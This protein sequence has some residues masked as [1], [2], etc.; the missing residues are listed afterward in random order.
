MKLLYSLGVTIVMTFFTSTSFA[1]LIAGDIAFIGYNT[2]GTDNFAFITLADIP[3]GEVIY[4]TEEGWD[5]SLNNWA[6]TTEGHVTY[7]APAGGLTCGT[8]IHINETTPDVFTVTGGGTAT[9]SSGASWSLSAGDQVLAYQAATPEP[10]TVPTFISGVHGDDG[11]GAPLSLD[12]TTGWNNNAVS[13]LGTARSNLPPGLTNGTNCISLFPAIGT[14]LDNAKYNGTLTGTSAALRAAINDRTN[15]IAD[16]TTPYGLDPG[17]FPAPS[18]TCAPPCTDPT[19]PTLTSTPATV[20]SGGTATLNITGTL[21][22][23][24][25]WQVYTGSCG[26]TNIGSTTTGTFAIPGPITVPTTYFVRGEGGCVTPGTCGT[27]TITPQALDDASF[28]Y[29]AASYCVSDAD[30]TPTITGLPG[31]TFSSTAGLSINA[32]T[33]QIDVSASTP[34]TYT[35]TYTTS[36]TCPNSSNV[37]VTIN[38][39]DDPSFSYSASSYCVSDADPTPTITGLAGGIFSST[40]GLSINA[41]TGTID[42]SAST[43]NTYTITYT[44]SGPCPNSSGVLVTISALDD[45]S[46]SYSASSFCPTGPDP[47]PTITGL[48]GGMFSSTAGLSINAGTG[49]I[50]VSASTPNTYTVTYTTAGPCPNSSNVSVTVG[51]VI[52]PVITCPGDQTQAVDAACQFILADYT[53]LATA[54]D[55]CTASPT[56]TQIPAPGTPVTG[57]VTVQLTANDGNGNTANCNFNVIGLDAVAP[58]IACPGDQ[59]GTVN[60]TCQFIL[61]D[62]T[63]LATVND[64]C[65]GTSVTQSPAPG[66]AVG[67][68]VTVITLTATDVSA[69]SA[70]CTFNVTVSDA[71][72]PTITCP[73][74]QTASLDA[75]CQFTLPDYTSLAT[76]TDNCTASPTVTQSPAAGTTVTGNTT[77]TLTATDGSGN[78]SSC[79]FD[80]IV[81]DA[82]APTAV[83]QNIT[84]FL[85][86]AGNATI[87]AADID[88][89]STDNCGPVTLSASTTSFTCA[90]I[91]LNNVT[92]TATDAALNTANCVAVVTVADTTAPVASCPGNQTETA[93]PTCDFTLPD[94]TGL[95]TASDNCG[96]TTVTQSPVAGTVI[97][98]NTTIT[99]TTTD[100]SG[101]STT[102]TFDVILTG[103]ST[104]NAVCQDVTVYLDA[105]GNAS[106]VP[107]DIDGGSTVGCGGT[108]NLAASQTSFTCADIPVGATPTADMVI[109]G[110]YDG[111]LTGG[112]PKGIELYVINDIADLSQ[113]GVGSANNGGGTDGEEFT[114]PAVSATAGQFIYIASEAPEFTNWFGFA[115]DYTDFSMAINGDDAVE[116][117]YQGAVIDVFGDINT[118]GT[119]QPWEYLDGWA[120]RMNDTGN[121][122]SAWTPSNWMYSGINVLDGETANAT[123]ASPVPVGTFT[124]NVATPTSVTLTVTDGQGG[125]ATCTANV[126]VLDTVSPVA[127]CQDATVYLDATGNATITAADVTNSGFQSYSVDQTGTF[128]PLSSPISGTTVSLGDDAVSPALP[129]GFNFDFYGNSYTDFYISSNGFMTFSSGTG[130]GCCSGQFLPNT[131]N[132][133][134][135]I[136]FAWEDLDPGNGG[137]P[138]INLVQYTT[139]GTAPNRVLVMEFYNV[140]HFPSGNNVTTQV[141]LY[142]TT[143]M[144]EIHTTNMPSDGGSHTMGLEN[145]DGTMATLVP[146]RNSQNWSATNDYVAFI[147]VFG[148]NT[149]NCGV[150]SE[151]IDISSFTCADLGAT[152]PVTM[153]VTDNSGNT[154]TCTSQVTVLDTIAPTFTCPADIVQDQDAGVCSASVTVPNIVT[155]D[156]CGGEIITW[157]ITTPIST[158]SNIGQIGLQGIPVGLTTVDVTVTDPSGNASNCSFTITVNDTVAPTQPVLADSIAECS[159]TLTAPTTTDNCN[160]TITG[161][162]TDPTTIST[163]GTTVVTWTFDDGS[164][165]ITTATQNVIIN[166]AIAPTASDLDTVFAECI[167]DVA[168]DI[169]LVDDEADNCTAAPVVAYVGDV[170]SNGTGCNDTITRTYSVTDDA[171]NATNVE[172]IIIVNDTTAPTASNPITLNV[173]CLSDVPSTTNATAWVTDEADNCGNPIVTWLSDVSTNGTGC[174]DTI[175]RTFEVADACGNSIQ[176]TQLII[177]ND[178]VAPVLDVATL[179]DVTGTCDVTPATPTATDNCEGTINGVPDV[180]LPITAIGTTTV[181]WTFTDNCGN[182]VSQ[183][184]NVTVTGVDVGTT[185]ASDGITMIATNN[186]A[187]VTYQWIDCETNQPVAGATNV[188]F[189]PTYGSDFAVIVTENG[190]T[191]TS[192]C[193]NSTVGLEQ[194]T[195]EQF[196]MYPNPTETG[197]FTIQLDDVLKEVSVLDMTGRL[198][199]VD[200]NLEDKMVNVSNLV[201]GAYI[202]RVV[203]EKEQ[204]LVGT[205]RVQ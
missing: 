153:T 3:S 129:I 50:D 155:S 199:E 31:G 25:A 80:V 170:A 136:A 195:L 143:N 110:V 121:D 165:N 194:L 43:P 16:N 167:G 204:E 89:G 160:G 127:S 59:V 72:A 142:E 17:N 164:G 91:G 100:A 139:I 157:T 137:Q 101:N 86:G 119:G 133:N 147:P 35:V 197:S 34:N 184:Q 201:N 27:I 104:L 196:I 73:G 94:Y 111:P 118:D 126:T 115:P 8:I 42:V 58:T 190:C 10:A 154:G 175:T 23:A 13:P 158:Y 33:G 2:D 108:L 62:Y 178:D 183:T 105:T 28:S 176:V 63:A 186:N 102:C 74:N 205:I 162:T 151:T 14:E 11:N 15:W 103:V 135:L 49:T 44:T 82:T 51:D 46:F 54:T 131:G 169:T 198:V 112:T 185:M 179:P 71:Q 109:T 172:Q 9:L 203:T 140:D 107:A 68:G 6:G 52:P 29:S 187:G 57:G 130:S 40:A 202:V 145:I 61:P 5:L 30:P 166:D 93:S 116:L 132:P 122:G 41:S 70:N 189:T 146:G 96:S 141:H 144:I 193:V 188:N 65:P 20:C 53:G 159:V 60:A 114:F 22:D 12:A 87:T 1:Q 138:A 92:L 177:V 47:T 4:F 181:T 69:N 171:G 88:A 180:S 48:A 79:T 78:N 168:I 161:T 174:N 85:D 191:D 128:A 134:N 152:V 182:S 97:T 200:V 113:Y 192:A 66:T 156:N 67:L 76:A 26:G 45:P 163:Q 95:V 99:M 125:S 75:A 18:V 77:I 81:T 148:G 106:I 98:S 83:C 55:N 117:F 90:D 120:Y 32:S 124:M 56:I 39:L 64:N 19:V 173:V 7:T 123:A 37:V 149:D 36:G 84:V 150:D 21:N 38:A 24:T